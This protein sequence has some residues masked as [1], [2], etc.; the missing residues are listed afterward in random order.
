MQVYLREEVARNGFQFKFA[1]ELVASGYK[2]RHRKRGCVWERERERREIEAEIG[3]DTGIAWQALKT[4]LQSIAK[5]RQNHG[6]RRRRIMQIRLKAWNVSATW[7][8][9]ATYCCC[10]S[11][12][13]SW[14]WL[15]Q[16]C[17][18]NLCCCYFWQQFSNC[19]VANMQATLVAIVPWWPRWGAQWAAK[20]VW[21]VGMLSV[22][23]CATLLKL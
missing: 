1:F 8:N 3:A 21:V 17:V 14:P 19:A 12:A 11:V 16:L 13:A 5:A 4:A 10:F 18:H 2:D 22:F 6:Q 15:A 20:Q 9:L 23:R 7:G